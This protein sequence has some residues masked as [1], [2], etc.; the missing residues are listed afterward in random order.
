M[1]RIDWLRLW[2]ALAGF[3]ALSSVLV[4]LR[5]ILPVDETRYLTV[6]WE[7]W[8]G[9]SKLVP[10][11][12]GDIYGHKP[13][14][15]FWL[16]NLVWSVTGVHDW[17]GR[18]VGP[19]FGVISIALTARLARVL[20]PDAPTRAGISA[21]ILASGL[22]FLLFGTATMFDTLLTAAVLLAMLAL[23]NLRHSGGLRPVLML[24]FALAFGVL[25][26]GPVVL[27][28]V[29]PVALLMP[30]WAEKQTRPALKGWYLSV[31]LS[32]AVALGLVLIW[33]GPALIAG[34]AEYRD[35]VLWR[36]SAGRMV[37]A[38]DHK[39]PLWFFAALLPLYLWP[40]GWSR[41]SLTR[42]A[43]RSMAGTEQ[44]RFLGIWALA[45]LL[46]F[47]AI[48]SKQAHYL[49]PEL[50][51]LALLLSGLSMGRVT[52]MGR[53][54]LALPLMGLG[55]MAIA[56]WSGLV[57]LSGDPAMRLT[58]TG[59]GS[60]V[61]VSVSAVT[62]LY[63]LRQRE[64]VTILTAAA[65]VLGLHLLVQPILWGQFDPTTIAGYLAAGQSGG[66]ATTDLKYAGQFS[67]AG[68]LSQPMTVL[69][70]DAAAQDWLAV[71]PGGTILTRTELTDPRL[72]IQH[73]AEF[74][75][76]VYWVYRAGS[77][78]P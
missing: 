36:Q 70:D 45:V 55:V 9:G 63:L 24:G 22:V 37:S 35:E 33:L 51:A 1:T 14:L 34:G 54:G 60:V 41:E 10:H 50:P 13:P 38:F 23:V 30:L 53:I 11:L 46:A 74:Q 56:D 3:A 78:Q 39:R 31:G 61:A 26:K 7:M 52:A 6:A 18:L 77:V 17:A 59:M 67:Y 44:A 71:H 25:A 48:S 29:M 28:H 21:L 62:G 65:T 49:V 64:G 20:W 19:A 42:L 69:G 32:I 75:G 68:R 8:Q 73:S 58:A 27:L 72:S 16:I 12:N 4:S 15:L 57:T 66:I 47:S 5:P 2:A 43:P 40:W 76:K